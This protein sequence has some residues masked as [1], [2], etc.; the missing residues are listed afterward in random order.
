M[1]SYI[2]LLR[3]S[4]WVKNLFIFAPLVFSKN[5]FEPHLLFQTVKGFLA[6]CLISSSVYVVNDIFDRDEDKAH[7]V[8]CKRPIASGDV[9]IV[10]GVL[11]SIVLV[12]GTFVIT[13]SL[14]LRFFNIISLYFVMQFFYSLTLKKIVILDIFIIAAG[15]MLR[16]IS[17][18]EAISVQ[19][20]SWITL[21][22]MFLSLFL[23]AAKRRGEL[24]LVNEMNH[25]IQRKV[26]K[27]YSLDFINSMMIISATGM[28]ISYAL[29]TVAGRTVTVFGTENL[30]F[31]TIFVLFGIFRYFYLV[32][33]KNM[34][35]NP[36]A[37]LS[38]DIP[39]FL[40]LFL[41]F[42]ACLVIIYR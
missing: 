41:W 17:G 35:E 40:N 32:I 1:N 31:T 20:S 23:A 13:L 25:S 8:K 6:F 30:I 24:V 34:G 14:P 19:V 15:F 16:V 28:A 11:L 42:I 5:L 29:Y 37:I 27:E 10:A 26:L 39:T 7:P 22:T 36:V 3:P 2:R 18:A 33:N 21:C 9:S 4:Q 12:L 38:K